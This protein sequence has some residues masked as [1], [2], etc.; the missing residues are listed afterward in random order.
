MFA[1]Q[2]LG[3][4]GVIDAAK[5][6]GVKLIGYNGDIAPFAPTITVT[7]VTDNYKK[8]FE[9]I[10]KSVKAG[11]FGGTSFRGGLK[12]DYAILA[13]FRGSVSKE[14]EGQIES[15]KQEILAGKIIPPTI[16]GDF[17]FDNWQPY[18]E[19]LVKK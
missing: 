8:Y 12:G 6:K 1:L 3:I 14:V 2:N 16:V 7:S 15:I 5:P 10:I 11:T 19:T 9:Y 13:P 17:I 4:Y 18:L